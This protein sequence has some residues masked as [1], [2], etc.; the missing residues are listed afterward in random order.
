MTDGIIFHAGYHHSMSIGSSDT[1]AP[2]C[3]ASELDADAVV[4]LPGR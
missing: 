4:V 3:D 1:V 2:V